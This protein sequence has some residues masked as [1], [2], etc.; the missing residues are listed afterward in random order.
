MLSE[1]DERVPWLR[2][3]LLDPFPDVIGP[4]HA[5]VLAVLAAVAA[6][7]AFSAGL[8]V[9]AGVLVLLNGYLD[10]LDGHLAR[11]Q[12]KASERGDF[13]DHSFDR[14]ADAALFIGAAASPL[15]NTSM[16][17]LTAIAVLL[18]S[19]LGTQAQA[20]TDERLYAGMVGRSDRIVLL[21]LGALLTPLHAGALAIAVGLVLVFSV[22]TIIQRSRETW[23]RLG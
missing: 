7:G 13:I 6:A 19:Y 16:G 18:V 12:G 11:R 22:V 3:A 14:F 20:L 23:Q 9:V 4:M 5:S 21:A 17:L 2:S 15:V 10:I 8:G 1:I